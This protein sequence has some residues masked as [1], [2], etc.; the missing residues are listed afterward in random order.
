MYW[1]VS[2]QISS[3]A[4]RIQSSCTSSVSITGAHECAMAHEVSR[5]SPIAKIC[6][7]FVVDKAVIG[8]FSANVSVFPSQYDSA[9]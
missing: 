4:V 8:Q 7:Q 3:T 5:Q 6:F 2:T 9:D 1:D